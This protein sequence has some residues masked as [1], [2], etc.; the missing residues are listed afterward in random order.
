MNIRS[1]CIAHEVRQLDTIIKR[2]K[3]NMAKFQARLNKLNEELMESK[4][5]EKVEAFG[6]ELQQ[7]ATMVSFLLV[8]QYIIWLFM[9]LSLI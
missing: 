5:A 7:R 6:S 2:F 9:H 1:V 8:K 3:S 4:V